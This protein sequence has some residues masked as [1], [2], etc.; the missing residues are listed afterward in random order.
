M[1]ARYRV[2]AD[3]RKKEANSPRSFVL[4]GKRRPAIDNSDIGIPHAS[5][6]LKPPIKGDLLST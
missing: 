2:N 5:I 1:N 3:I 6:L 4:A